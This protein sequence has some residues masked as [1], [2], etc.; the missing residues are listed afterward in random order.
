MIAWLQ[1]LA[2]TLGDLFFGWT[3]TWGADAGLLIVSVLSA[4][5]V[6]AIRYYL[7]PRDLLSRIRSDHRVLRRRIRDAKKKS[8]FFQAKRLT[9]FRQR[10]S[11]RSLKWEMCS[12][13]FMLP[14]IGGLAYWTS[15]RLAYHPLQAGDVLT[16]Q[17]R[18]PTSAETELV[19]LRPRDGIVSQQPIVELEI[20]KVARNKSAMGDWR[21]RLTPEFD[22]HESDSPYEVVFVFRGQ[23]YKHSITSLRT[24]H[25]GVVT[26]TELEPVRCFGLVP[27]TSFLAPWM[28][29]YLVISLSLTFLLR[30]ALRVP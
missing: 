10:M 11:I 8:E 30:K 23:E 20:Q 1:Q 15:Q 18:A 22:K 16:L 24:E 27:E 29:A 19:H 3:L 4:I 26:V 6:I 2:L 9:A 21:I 7:M 25:E 13:V 5:F 14:I 17:F 28:K 12:L